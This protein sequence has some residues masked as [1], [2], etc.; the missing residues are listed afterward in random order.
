MLFSRYLSDTLAM[1]VISAWLEVA[2]LVSRVFAV[3]V[4]RL[5]RWEA[6]SCGRFEGNYI[7]SVNH[8]LLLRGLSG[9]MIT[10]GL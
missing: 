8:L 2:D 1:I 4:S 5:Y 7:N 6:D 10:L 3:V 9:C